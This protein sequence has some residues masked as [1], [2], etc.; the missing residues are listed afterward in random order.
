MSKVPF[1]SEQKERLSSLK[2]MAI[3]KGAANCLSGCV[4][5]MTGTL[6]ALTRARAKKLIEEYGGEVTSSIN[7]KTNV[8]LKGYDEETSKKLQDAQK[9]GIQ[10][11]DQ[12][13]LFKFI[14]STDPDKEEKSDD[15]SDIIQSTT[16]NSMSIPEIKEYIDKKC[17][18]QKNLL[19]YLDDSQ[20]VEE[21][22]QTLS[23]VIENQ[24]ISKNK[25]ELKIFFN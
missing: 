3:P 4:F 1:C 21:K 20:N 19:D 5:V 7:S 9:K 12:E 15:I 14:A 18:L 10:I 11:T 23:Q 6:P 24:N 16:N 17:D 13:G 2:E 22:Y 8:I 25:I